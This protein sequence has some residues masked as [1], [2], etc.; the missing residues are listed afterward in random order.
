MGDWRKRNLR[1]GE[2]RIETSPRRRAW[3]TGPTRMR[4][5]PPARACATGKVCHE[6]EAAAKVEAERKMDLGHVDPGCHLQA[7]KCGAC[8]CWHVGN[9]VVVFRDDD[10]VV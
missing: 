4:I 1:K 7:Y 8:H 2:R 10:G 3:F 9:R 5:T 6:T